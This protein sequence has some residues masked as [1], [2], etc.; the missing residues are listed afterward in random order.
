MLNTRYARS[1]MVC[2]VDHLASSAGVAMLERGGS[3]ADAAIAANAVLAVTAPHM[4]GLGG[5]LFALVHD[6]TGAP[7]ALN[8]SGRAGSGADAERL[9][10]EGHD[11]MPHRHDVRSTPVPG[12]ADGWL[13]LH[14]RYGRLP[15]A[16]V[17]AP[18][19]GHARDGFPASPLMIP[20]LETVGPLCEDFAS[21][22]RAGD[23]IRRPGV[24]RALEALADGRDGFYLGEFGQGLLEVGG[25]EYTEDDLAK[26]SAEWVDPLRVRAFGHDVWT[27]PPNSQGYLLLLALGIAEGLDLPSDPGDPL[28]AHLLVEAARMAGH[29]RPEL[30]FDGASVEEALGSAAARRALIHPARRVAVRDLT[31]PGDTTYLCAVDGDGMGVSLIQSNAAGFGGMVFEPRTGINLHNR[32]IGFSLVPGHPAEY[33]PGRRPPH[34]LVPALVTRP[35]GSLR[36]VVGTMGGDAQPQILLQVLTRLLAHGQTPGEAIGAARWRLASGGT[37]FDTWDAPD[38][39]M[40]EVEAGGPW[41]DGLRDRGHPVGAAPYGSTFGHAHLIDLLPSGVLAGAADPR[42]IIGAAA[43]L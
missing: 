17:L 32:G 23:L 2:T 36:S 12:C 41:G 14:G 11:R 10:A 40:V 3:A 43:G 15:A 38:Q 31:S 20:A 39:A 22:R 19:I 29:D 25:G 7:A 27:M 35:D 18:A 42:S 8:A 4:C 26:A 37:G 21:A 28:W 34:T 1:G 30:L 24:A 16:E 33:G 13:A 5:D 6:G 9:R